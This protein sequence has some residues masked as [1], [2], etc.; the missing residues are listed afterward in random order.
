MTAVVA[1]V[2][3]RLEEVPATVAEDDGA[4]VRAECRRANQALSFEVPLGLA[5]VLATVVEV[6]LCDD[7]KGADGGEHPALGAVDLVHSVTFSYRT[8][9]AASW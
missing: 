9:T 6:A 8:A 7:T 5:S 4:V 2:P 1:L 3:I